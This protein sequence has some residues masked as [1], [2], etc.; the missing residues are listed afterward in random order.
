MALRKQISY[1]WRLF[2]P[3][4]LLLVVMMGTLVAYQYRRERDYRM[5]SI[6]RQLQNISN[7]VI[8]AYERHR[9]IEEFVEFIDFFMDNTLYEGLIVS[10]YDADGN[11]MAR[12]GR[13]LQTTYDDSRRVPELVDAD[14]Q[15]EG[16][17][18]RPKIETPDKLFFFS[19]KKSDDGKIY[20]HTA[21]PMTVSIVDAI[22][23]EPLMW[24][25]IFI[26]FAVAIMIAYA[27]T[28]YIGRNI[29]LLRDFARRAAENRDF[30]AVS[31]WFPRDELGD[32]SRQIVA[33]YREKDKALIRSEHEHEVALRATEE[34]AR[35][36]RQMTNNINHE[37]KTPVGVIK[38]Y[39]DT[40]ADSP[41][42]PAD[43]RDRFIAKAREH[44]D[45]LCALLNDV[46]TI[47]RLD[48]GG[49]K[50]PVTKLD[51]H[52]VVYSVAN[53]LEAGHI[54]GD[55][56]FEYKIPFD[57]WIRGNYNL[58]TAMLM[59]LVK[60]AVAYSRGTRM[61]VT[62]VEQNDKFYTFC[63]ADN[64]VGVGEEHLPHLFERFYRVDQGRAR[65]TGGTGLGLPIV[66][67]TVTTLG[68]QILVRNAVNGGLEF[69]FSLPKWTP[70]SE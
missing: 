28:N 25:I 17:V 41:D 22:S 14:E 59:N 68:G 20:V 49:D 39:L 23:T 44:V 69:V 57:C 7:S 10:V 66:R 35:M 60:N 3:L 64:G 33:I 26:L 11:V 62:L 63:F 2:I 43:V 19:A 18:L 27:G 4:V 24:F 29:K 37:L 45:R 34:K 6:G 5:E 54:C 1:Q 12:I 32:I 38:G 58:L 55:M 42:L 48:D 8:N 70:P 67:N 21:M 50:V 31:N 51:F 13:P 47:T 9:N 40:I 61:T 30:D 16:H 15:G 36:R 46:S 52:E 56:E 53:D 65:K